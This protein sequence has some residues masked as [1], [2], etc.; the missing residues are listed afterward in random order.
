MLGGQPVRDFNRLGGFP[1]CARL[2]G[3]RLKNSRKM[4]RSA[5]TP[6]VSSPVPDFLPRE[7]QIF[8]G[9][10]VELCSCAGGYKLCPG[11]GKAD[12]S[13]L[14]SGRHRQWPPLLPR[15][16]TRRAPPRIFP[17]SLTPPH[18]QHQRQPPA[19]ASSLT[20]VFGNAM[21]PGPVASGW[22]CGR[23]RGFTA[24]SGP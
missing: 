24:I 6:A 1:G 9:Q 8:P 22:P 23:R 5:G 11:C 3:V 16:D 7:G 4:S 19:P 21:H 10:E 20:C 17:T 18:P 2:E 15:Y 14:W 13:E 12:E